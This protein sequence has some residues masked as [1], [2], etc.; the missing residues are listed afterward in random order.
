MTST[1]VLVAESL[2]DEDSLREL[3]RTRLRTMSVGSNV[4]AGEKNILDDTQNQVGEEGECI[5]LLVRQMHNF[6]F[7]THTFVVSVNGRCGGRPYA[8]KRML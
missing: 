5:L 6:R 2:H 4:F 1:P 8:W 7:A 3:C